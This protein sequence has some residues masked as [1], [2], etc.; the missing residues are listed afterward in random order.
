[1][2]RLAVRNSKKSPNQET[3][4]GNRGSLKVLND[5]KLILKS[6]HFKNTVCEILGSIKIMIIFSNISAEIKKKS[7]DVLLKMITIL[8]ELRIPQLCSKNEQTLV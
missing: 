1:M 2:S 5:T 3:G 6:V 4:V 7:A 8:K